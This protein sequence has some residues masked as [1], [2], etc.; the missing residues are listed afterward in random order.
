MPNLLIGPTLPHGFP[1]QNF[2]NSAAHRGNTDKILWLTVDT[3]VK[4]RRL[5]KS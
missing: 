3:L 2:A 5:I 1:R 4:F